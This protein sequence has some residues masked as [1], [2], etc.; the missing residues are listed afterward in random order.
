MIGWSGSAR[1]LA[2]E[3]A[4]SNPSMPASD[5][6]Q[7]DGEVALQKPSQGFGA[8]PARMRFAS[9]SAR[10]ASRASRLFGLS[11]DEDVGPRLRL[12]VPAHESGYRDPE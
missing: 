7:N 11:S 6:E 10:M 1:A 8:E 2:D 4:V 9:S 5:I 3:V 12:W